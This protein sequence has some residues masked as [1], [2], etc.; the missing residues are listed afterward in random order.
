MVSNSP[1]KNTSIMHEC[2]SR[3]R[4]ITSMDM[5]FE[6]TFLRV[7]DEQRAHAAHTAKRS[8]HTHTRTR[9]KIRE[10]PANHGGQQI[11]R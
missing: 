7:E 1:N 9:A 2:V 6:E 8:A 4:R 10:A 5:D 11:A 3:A